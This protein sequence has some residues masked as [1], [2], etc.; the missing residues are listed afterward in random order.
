MATNLFSFVKSHVQILDVVSEYVA[1]KKAGGYHKGPCPFHSERTASFT[2]SPLKE[3]FYCFGCHVTGDVIGFIEKAEH[4]SPLDA[5][6]FLI[7]RF[8]LEVPQEILATAPGASSSDERKRFHELYATV[9]QWSHEQLL[10]NPA[11]LNYFA[12]RGFTQETLRNWCIGYLPGGPGLKLLISYLATKKFLI[13]DLLKWH[14]VEQ[15]RQMLY[16]PFEER[17]LFPIKDHV[18]RIC[19]FGGRIF[20]ANDERAKYYNSRE[21]EFFLKGSLL[22][23]FDVA[24]AAMHQKGTT[25]LVEGYTDCIAMAQAGYGN[26][27]ATLGTACTS[28][29]LKLLSRHVHTVYVLYDGDAAGQKAMLRLAELCW[30]VNLELRVITLPPSQD[31]ASLLQSPATSLDSYVLKAKDLFSFFIETL[32]ANFNTLPLSEKL[33]TGHKIIDMIRNIREPLKQGLLLQ[34]AAEIMGVPTQIL[35]EEVRHERPSKQHAPAQDE[36]TT[37]SAAEVE[38]NEIP[39]IEKKLVSAILSGTLS[40][41]KVLSAHIISAFSPLLQLILQARIAQPASRLAEFITSLPAEHQR[42]VAQL[43]ASDEED[44]RTIEQLFQQFQKKHWQMQMHEVRTALSAA[45]AEGN[46]SHVAQLLA[47]FEELKNKIKENR[48]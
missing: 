37:L 34:Q 21:H 47:Q 18:G 5:A 39:L 33:K 41:E 6:K 25:F 26:V 17:L 11:A 4:C 28:E 14:L 48:L 8:Q 24:K 43:T 13:D 44:S 22:F 23:G 1:L 15:G 45:Q 27:V 12:Q 38:A 30:E 35:F 20:K 16:S 2:V 31:P 46:A 10:K 19:G 42:L 36:V 29:H 3:I 9:A 40:L 32:G 7:E